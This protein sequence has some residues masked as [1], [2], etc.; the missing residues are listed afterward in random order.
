M[1]HSYGPRKHPELAVVRV[2]QAEPPAPPAA[3]REGFV[4]DQQ[5]EDAAMLLADGSRTDTMVAE[6]LGLRGP[7]VT[8]WRR[9]RAF[10]ERVEY[11]RRERSVRLAQ[12]SWANKENRVEEL[13]ALYDKMRKVIDERAVLVPKFVELHKLGDVPGAD[14]GIVYPVIKQFNVGKNAKTYYEFVVDTAIIKQMGA[15]F[16]QLAEETGQKISYQKS[17]Q[18][19]HVKQEQTDMVQRRYI[20]VNI[21]DV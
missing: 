14:T 1:R 11:F 13:N 3:T 17:A 8:K 10:E 18:T 7:T 19:I 6:I 21:E 2:V 16:D 15:T 5:R 4:W 12:Y 9:Y 20:G